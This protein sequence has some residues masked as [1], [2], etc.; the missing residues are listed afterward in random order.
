LKSDC[1]AATRDAIGK[2]LENHP[3]LAVKLL[4]IRY[5]FLHDQTIVRL[6]KP[7]SSSTFLQGRSA[8]KFSPEFPKKS[9][10]EVA[11]AKAI[12][13]GKINY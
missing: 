2:R 5:K 10:E 4:K 9:D 12:T 13:H 1:S 3:R 11:L 7:Q 8:E 6:D